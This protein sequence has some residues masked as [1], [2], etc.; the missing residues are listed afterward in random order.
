VIVL[1]DAAWNTAQQKIDH[2]T[3]NPAT[4]RLRAVRESRYLTVPFAGG[5]AG[6]RSVDTA[7]SLQDQLRQLDPLDP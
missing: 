5:E 1:V 2:L 7:L 4:A 6:V 3:A